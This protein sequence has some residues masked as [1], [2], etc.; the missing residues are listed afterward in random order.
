MADSVS[1]HCLRY[2]IENDDA[3][4]LTTLLS[5]AAAEKIRLY[6]SE[7]LVKDGK[8]P[9]ASISEVYLF[10]GTNLLRSRFKLST[11]EFYAKYATDLEETKHR[12]TLIKKIASLML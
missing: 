5:T 6:T 1:A 2:G 7:Q 9:L 11:P 3:S 10:V 12:I 8:H 4:V